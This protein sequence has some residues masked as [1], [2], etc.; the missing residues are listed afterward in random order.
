MADDD[1]TDDLGDL[2]DGDH[3]APSGD[4]QG[5]PLLLTGVQAAELLCISEA[6]LWQLVKRDRLRCVEFVATGFKR[7]IRRFRLRDLL[8]FIERSVS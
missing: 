7:P 4:S 8:D 1:Q 5:A 3:D 2:G 6:T